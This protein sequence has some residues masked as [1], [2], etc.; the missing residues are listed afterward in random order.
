VY[1]CEYKRFVKILYLWLYTMLIVDY[2]ST[3]VGWDEIP[4]P[5]IDCK[6]KQVKEKS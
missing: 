3:D 4:V 5:Q 1:P 2:H 6:S